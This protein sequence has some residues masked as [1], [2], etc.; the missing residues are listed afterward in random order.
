MTKPRDQWNWWDRNGFWVFIA[1]VVTVT[2]VT[3]TTSVLLGQTPLLNYVVD[4]LFCA[5]VL[6]LVAAFD[7]AMH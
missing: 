7:Q 5:V 1:V 3:F 6:I 2:A 4:W